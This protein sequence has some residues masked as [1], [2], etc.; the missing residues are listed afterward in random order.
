M[1]KFKLVRPEWKRGALS[2]LLAGLCAI[3][4]SAQSIAVSPEPSAVSVTVYRDPDRPASREPNLGWLG[5][6]ALITETRTIDIPAGDSA[7]R[8]EGVAGGIVP[9]SAI[10]AGLPSGVREKNQDAY[11]L[12]PASLLDASLGARVRLRRTSLATGAVREEEAVVRTGANGAAIVQTAAGHEALRCSGLPETLIYPRV[13]PG[14]SAKPT[15]S[16]AT[17]SVRRTRATVTLSYL[18]TGFD[19]QANYVATLSPDGRSMELLG[20]V[21]LASGDE[22]SFARAGA[23][24]VAGRLNREGDSRPDRPRG[25]PLRLTCY[26][27]GTTTS[28]ARKVEV[29]PSIPPPPAEAPMAISAISEEI[30]VTGTRIRRMT[31]IQE[32]LGDLK[33]YRIP[34]PVT[35]AARSQKQVG[36]LDRPR[37]AVTEVYRRRVFPG[38]RSDSAS[39][40]AVRTFVTRNRPADGLGLPLPAGGVALFAR[41]GGRTV[42]VGQGSIADRAV[43]EEVE[44]EAGLAPGVTSRLVKGED[45]D[46]VDVYRLTVTND[47]ATPVPFEAD[48]EADGLRS[49]SGGS[50]GR[51]NGRPLWRV[52]V[53]ANGIATL[54]FR[55]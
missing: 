42:L 13:P 5:G 52:T 19:W 27:L 33:L 6:F 12:S 41:A 11:L 43:G 36:L 29:S 38:P 16:V 49:V 51:K 30:V 50:V 48:F 32:E 14:L 44:I 37:V 28:E 23:Q 25:E 31:A 46:P 4:A 2:L 34:E 26:P 20:W 10:V 7:I 21:T 22:T 47:R 39:L 1:T 35:V 55:V 17:T 45:G 3:S 15:L 18:A 24:A 8:F 54:R 9:T 40:P 53:P